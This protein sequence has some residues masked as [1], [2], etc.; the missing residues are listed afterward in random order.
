MP[1][2][3]STVLAERSE[4]ARRLGVR[5]AFARERAGLSQAAAAKALGL[6]Q[7]AVAKLERGK[8]QLLFLEALRLAPLYGVECTDLDPK[9]RRDADVRG[10]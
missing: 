10:S 8:R 9:E 1:R 7:S 2:T 6:P 5:L 4:A 3:R